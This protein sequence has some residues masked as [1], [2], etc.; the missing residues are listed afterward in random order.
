[1]SKT[2]L[3]RHRDCRGVEDTHRSLKN[4]HG[5]EHFHVWKKSVN[6]GHF[7]LAYFS[8]ALACL[9]HIKRRKLGQYCTQEILKREDIRLSRHN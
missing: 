4:Y 6:L 7:Q 2:L 1:M 9:E 8:C 5:G 3:L